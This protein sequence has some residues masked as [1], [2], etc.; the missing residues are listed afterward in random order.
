MNGKFSVLF[1]T[2]PKLLFNK[3][4]AQKV[5]GNQDFHAEVGSLI[6]E[7]THHQKISSVLGYR[8]CV[9]TVTKRGE[10][11]EKPSPALPEAD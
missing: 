7:D 11:V 3:H 10:R 1:L 6:D 4:F 2:F 5:L 9:I 8:N